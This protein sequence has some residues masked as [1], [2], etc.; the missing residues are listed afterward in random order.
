M[1][2]EW[3]TRQQ[4]DRYAKRIEKANLR[5]FG[6]S[7]NFTS[8][9]RHAMQYIIEVRDNNI[10]VREDWKSMMKQAG[11]TEKNP[12]TNKA[13]VGEVFIRDKT[14]LPNGRKQ[15]LILG[16]IDTDI[17]FDD[18]TF[19]LISGFVWDG[20]PVVIIHHEGREQAA[21]NMAGERIDQIACDHRWRI[22]RLK[23]GE[24]IGNPTIEEITQDFF[25]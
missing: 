13:V 21:K 8:I 17:P 16:V 20:K 4:W 3:I 10:L 9:S 5:R 6:K 22:P 19:Y 25:G 1:S 23:T 7:L 14:K 11:K 12:I 2:F 15:F 18:E 24:Y